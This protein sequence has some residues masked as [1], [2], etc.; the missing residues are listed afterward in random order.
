[1]GVGVW[2][3]KDAHTIISVPVQL[4]LGMGTGYRVYRVQ[5][6]RAG[7]YP[8]IIYASGAGVLSE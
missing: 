1:M 7:W 2:E 6:V 8:G 3:L 4:L 5:T